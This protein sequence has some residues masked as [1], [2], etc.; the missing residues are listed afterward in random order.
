M[1]VAAKTVWRCTA[2]GFAE[3]RPPPPSLKL[4]ISLHD[5]GCQLV[6]MAGI[7]LAIVSNRLDRPDI[8][9][10]G[11]GALALFL[12]LLSALS[13]LEEW[14][15][16]RWQRAQQAASCPRCGATGTWAHATEGG[17]I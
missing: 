2:C 4:W 11:G 15:R 9:L 6:V 12:V 1:F 13:A 16:R 17:I 7:V 5:G 10:W 14:R 3:E 8:L